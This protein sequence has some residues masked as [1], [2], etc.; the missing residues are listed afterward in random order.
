MSR[1]WLTLLI[2]RMDAVV[3]IYCLAA[4]PY[5][6]SESK[7]LTPRATRRPDVSLSGG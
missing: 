5:P 7:A 1:E 6:R 4:S 2:R 3:S